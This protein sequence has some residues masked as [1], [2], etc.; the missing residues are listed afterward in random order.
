MIAIIHIFVLL[1]RLHQRVATE[2]VRAKLASPRL[3][4]FHFVPRFSMNTANIFSSRE[5]NNVQGKRG[6][7]INTKSPLRVANASPL[8]TLTLCLNK[9]DERK[10]VDK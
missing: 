2:R 6:S 3:L 4:S 10:I 5:I 7:G 9:N 8:L 1:V